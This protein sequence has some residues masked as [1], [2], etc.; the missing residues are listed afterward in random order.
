MITEHKKGVIEFIETVYLKEMMDLVEYPEAPYSKFLIIIQGIEFLGA[1]QDNH[2][3]EK[4][5]LSRKRFRKGMVLMGEK[6]CD[7][8]DEVNEICF[9]RDFRCP[10]I[11]QFKHNQKKIT[12]ATK[13]GIN[14]EELHLT[15][16]ENGQL[17]IVLEDF[18]ADIQQ[19][20]Q[21]LIEQINQGKYNLEKLSEPYLTIHKIEEMR[22][23]SS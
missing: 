12:L 10:M 19:A 3:F 17:Y 1:C 15:K 11:H 13:A 2:I 8:L 20:A 9:Y 22:F 7:F 6:Y 4:E 16:N 23:I 21:L 18:Y 5:G 14:Y